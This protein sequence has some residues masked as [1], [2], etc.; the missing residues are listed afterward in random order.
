MAWEMAA[1]RDE[2]PSFVRMFCM[3]RATVC[4]LRCSVGGDVPVVLAGG[5]QLQHLNL[6]FGQ[7][8]RR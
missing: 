5:D 3:C 8:P 1:A 4:S 6:S 7:D 2:T